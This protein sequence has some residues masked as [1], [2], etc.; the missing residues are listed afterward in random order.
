MM[1]AIKEVTIVG[2]GAAGWLTAAVIAAELLN[3]IK[4]R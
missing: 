4:Q 3:A 1:D 2:G